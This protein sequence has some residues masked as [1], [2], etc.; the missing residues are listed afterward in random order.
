MI[1]D[2]LTDIANALLRLRGAFAKHRL[3]APVALKIASREEM[4]KLG[5]L[6]RSSTQFDY[7]ADLDAARGDGELS[8]NVCG[9]KISAEVGPDMRRVS[10]IAFQEGLPHSRRMR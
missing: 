4:I 2:A 1:D 10:T 8:V 9:V 3:K 7:A 5:T 6:L